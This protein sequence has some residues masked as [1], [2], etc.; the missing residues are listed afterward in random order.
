[1]Y[2]IFI[3]TVTETKSRE[4]PNDQKSGENTATL[5]LLMQRYTNKMFK[6][7]LFWILDVKHFFWIRKPSL[8]LLPPR[9]AGLSTIVPSQFICPNVK[10]LAKCGFHIELRILVCMSG[11]GGSDIQVCA[12]TPNATNCHGTP[13]QL[14]L[15]KADLV[16]SEKTN[17]HTTLFGYLGVT[18]R[19]KYDQNM[20]QFCKKPAMPQNPPFCGLSMALSKT[21]YPLSYSSIKEN[22]TRIP[23][24]T[25]QTPWVVVNHPRSAGAMPRWNSR[26]RSCSS[27]AQAEIPSL[28]CFTASTGRST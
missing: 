24:K 12:P 26:C 21:S 25:P 1:M 15:E 17:T 5:K 20:L 6:N 27:D 4:G 9:E 2:R 8:H 19:G 11:L 7:N 23:C 14:T 3:R 10:S 22:H 13:K 16:Q 18:S 28:E